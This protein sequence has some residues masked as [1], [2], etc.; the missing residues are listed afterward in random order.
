MIHRHLDYDPATP[1]A[2]R[3][4]AAL[5]DLLDRGDL[6]DWAPLV[7]AVAADPDG[8]LASKILAICAAHPMYGTSTLWPRWI[9]G[10]RRSRAGAPPA[11]DGGMSLDPTSPARP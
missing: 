5:D 3:G 9:T 7:E 8:P 11:A 1:W 4:R 10:L 6:D 2:D